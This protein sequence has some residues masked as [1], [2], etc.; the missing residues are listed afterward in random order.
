MDRTLVSETS[1]VSSILA[2]S[3]DWR[4]A[5]TVIRHAWKACVLFGLAGSIPVL[6]AQV[7]ENKLK[8]EISK[9]NCVWIHTQR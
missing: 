2:E 8:Y 6:S 5:I 9:N 1:D 4:G 3:A 7:L